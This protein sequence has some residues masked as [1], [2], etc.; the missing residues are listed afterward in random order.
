MK[1]TTKA[2]LAMTGAGLGLAAAL[3]LA[4]LP[5]AAQ[6]SGSARQ[7]L[8]NPESAFVTGSIGGQWQSVTKRTERGHLIG[9][10]EA[11][12][13]MIEFISYTCPH[14]ASFTDQGEPGLELVLIGPGKMNLEVR[15]VVR[16]PLDLAVTMLVGCGDASGFKD[17]HRLFMNT[18]SQWLKKAQQSPASQQEIWARADGKARINMANALGLIDMLAKAGQSRSALSTC[19]L[20]EKAALALI[21]NGEADRSEFKFPGTPSFVLDGELIKDVHEWK[22]LYPVLSDHFAD[23]PVKQPGHPPRK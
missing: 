18:Q 2:P 4:A 3:A 9:N 6:K 10:P 21:E 8:A 1:F 5:A 17:R 13:R 7:D 16:N 12:S 22:T 20:D 23:A 15:S 19:L 11:E 14:C